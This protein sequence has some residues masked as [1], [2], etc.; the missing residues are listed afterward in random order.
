MKERGWQI[1]VLRLKEFEGEI[2][3]AIK[4][5]R[6]IE[7]RQR[8]LG[9]TSRAHSVVKLRRDDERASSDRFA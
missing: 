5:K 7:E 1:G 6:R 3:K 8:L 4:R 2:R 9:M